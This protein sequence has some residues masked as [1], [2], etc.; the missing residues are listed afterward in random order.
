MP[1]VARFPLLSISFEREEIPVGSLTPSRVPNEKWRFVDSQGHGHFWTGKLLPTLKWVVTGT[2]WVGDDFEHE[3][4]EIG[5]WRCSQCEEVV[6]PGMRV[7]FS[8]RSV[9]GLV[10]FTVTIGSESFVLTEEQYA[11]SVEAWA[12]ALREMRS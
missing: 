9:P 10:T 4:I 8:P 5:E 7:D 6:E 12:E 2:K 3:E 1:A 11:K